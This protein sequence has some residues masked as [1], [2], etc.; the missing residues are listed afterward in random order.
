MVP[1]STV[2]CT[3]TLSFVHQPYWPQLP[4]PARIPVAFSLYFGRFFEP[5]ELVRPEPALLAN[6]PPMPTTRPITSWTLSH[7]GLLNVTAPDSALFDGAC[8]VVPIALDIANVGQTLGSVLTNI[9]LLYDVAG[10]A[11]VNRAWLRGSLQRMDLALDERRTVR[12][13]LTVCPLSHTS[14]DR[15]IELE[16]VVR[17]VDIPVDEC[18]SPSGKEVTERITLTLPHDGNQDEVSLSFSRLDEE[19][20]PWGFVVFPACGMGL[21]VIMLVL[22]CY[23][24]FRRRRL[25][26]RI[27]ASWFMVDTDGH[28]FSCDSPAHFQSDVVFI[29]RLVRQGPRQVLYPA[30]WLKLRPPFSITH[31][32]RDGT[33]W[34]V[35]PARV[36][37]LLH[38]H[39]LVGSVSLRR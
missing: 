18:W 36:F 33:T 3:V 5:C 37:L 22:L 10:V 26:F 31:D 34:L 28:P 20:F 16:A 24:R 27:L 9:S 32:S 29:G 25:R 14:V 12:F 7:S 35:T 11:L 4:R 6:S 1:H 38:P 19:T 2:N 17:V 23:I 39:P 8:T 13:N 30:Q 15:L 21:L